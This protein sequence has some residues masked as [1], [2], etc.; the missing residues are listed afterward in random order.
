MRDDEKLLR[1]KINDLEKKKNQC[2]EEIDMKQR[3][4]QQLKEQ[5][6]NQKVEEA[7]QQYERVCKDLSVKEKIIEDMRMTLEEQEQTQVE[8]DQVL[9]AKLEEAERLATE[10][11]N[12][13]KMQ[14]S[15][16]QKQ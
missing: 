7:I 11:E 15:G 9:E 3:T 14:R 13:R 5:L 6:N 4:I 8:Q 12:G 1:V 10:L 16:N 2:S